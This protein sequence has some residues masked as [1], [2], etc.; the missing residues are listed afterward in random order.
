MKDPVFRNCTT[1]KDKKFITL[2]QFVLI[3]SPV[4][5]GE[6]SRHARVETDKMMDKI[7]IFKNRQA[8]IE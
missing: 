8:F 1:G 5:P 4:I 2:R 3:T 6:L 7:Y